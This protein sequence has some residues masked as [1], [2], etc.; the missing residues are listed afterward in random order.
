M[1]K[2]LSPAVF[3][4][5][6]NFAVGFLLGPV[7]IFWAVP[8]FGERAAE[9]MEQPIVLAAMF[10]AA[11]VTVTRFK[12]SKN[13]STPVF[14]GLLALTFMVV[15]EVTVVVLLRR[16]AISEYISSRDPVSGSV[17]LVMLLIFGLMPWL[18]TRK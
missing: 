11:R 13:D 7:R 9:L 4:F 3:Y 10:L 12:L 1:P 8:R 17:Y 15:A 5:F 18:V 6:L 16:V 2:V 14:V